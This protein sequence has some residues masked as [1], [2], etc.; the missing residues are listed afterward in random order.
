MFASI[1]DNQLASKL[2]SSEKARTG[3]KGSQRKK[4]VAQRRTGSSILSV[5][6]NETCGYAI[7]YFSDMS[8]IWERISQT[9]STTTERSGLGCI[10]NPPNSLFHTFSVT[11]CR[12]LE[13]TSRIT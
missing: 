2:M 6:T 5:L 13:A 8:S 10:I 9:L 12:I 7:H 4:R 3:E 1:G 11:D